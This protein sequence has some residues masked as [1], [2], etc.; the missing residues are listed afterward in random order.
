M[1]A[2]LFDGYPQA[3]GTKMIVGL[4]DAYSILENVTYEPSSQ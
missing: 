3:S 2:G 4:F 1:I